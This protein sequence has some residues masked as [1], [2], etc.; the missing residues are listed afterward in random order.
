MDFV[1][2]RLWEIEENELGQVRKGI[3]LDMLRKFEINSSFI[4][5]SE[6]GW[7]YLDEVQI[8]L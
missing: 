7:G 4:I 6:V 2:K 1:R 5:D 3:E 8:V